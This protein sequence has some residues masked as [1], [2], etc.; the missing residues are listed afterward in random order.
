MIL[1]D[2][3]RLLNDGYCSPAENM[4]RDETLL[5]RVIAGESPPCVRFYMWDPPGLSIGRFQKI[6]HGVDLEACRS[7]GVEVVRRLTGG[8]A[9]LHDDEITYSMI[10]PFTH[11]RFDGRGVIETYK[12]ISRALVKGLELSGV[13]STMAGNAPTRPDPAG[14]GVCFYTPTVN[15][16]VASCKKIIGSAQTREK[17]V[18]LQHGSIP[19]DFDLEKQF[20]VMGIP[21]E[22]REMFKNLF[23]NRATTISEQLGGKRPD[24]AELARNFS[25][26][27]EEVFDTE[28]VRSEYSLPEKKMTEHLV[29]TKYGNDNWNLKI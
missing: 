21:K 6:G 26:G 7:H 15:E 29:R 20:D 17:L 12:T 27:F 23:K 28:L 9:V 16:I 24:P 8:E 19:I 18:I 2:G 11:P 1:L 10:V 13:E 3:F 4:A 25:K 5:R 14:Q 22:N